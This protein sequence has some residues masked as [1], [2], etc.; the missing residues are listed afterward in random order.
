MKLGKITVMI[1]VLVILI[2][3]VFSAVVMGANKINAVSDESTSDEGEDRPIIMLVIAGL[4]LLMIIV[5][6]V[7]RLL[8]K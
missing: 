5:F 2:G 8:R 1:V 7:L 3:F 4:L 6:I